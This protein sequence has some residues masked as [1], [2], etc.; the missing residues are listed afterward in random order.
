MNIDTA[1]HVLHG[2]SGEVR[3]F[4]QSLVK[5]AVMLAGPLM[6]HRPSSTLLSDT[7]T[8]AVYCWVI[9]LDEPPPV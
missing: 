3:L 6:V 7:L 9:T 5:V 4:F 2:P 8:T 1:D